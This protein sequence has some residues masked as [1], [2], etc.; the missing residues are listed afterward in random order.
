MLRGI[1]VTG[2]NTIKM[3]DLRTV[4]N[5]LGYRNVQTYVQSGNIVFETTKGSPAQLSKQLSKAIRDAQGFDVPV[6]IRTV[7]EMKKIVS[8]NPFLK[9]RNIDTSKLHVTFLSEAPRAGSLENLGKIPAGP[10]RFHAVH[11]EIY[12]YCPDGYG[13]TKLSNA[14][15]EKTLSVGATTRNWRTSNTLL[16]MASKIAT[17]KY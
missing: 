17:E 11:N 14:M 16:E 4:C 3:Q 9:E 8:A 2:H 5:K 1:N 7:D 10:D 12:L 6:F 15:I 13:R